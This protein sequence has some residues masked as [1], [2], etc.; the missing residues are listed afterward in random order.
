[1]KRRILILLAAAAALLCGCREEAGPRSVE[2]F[3]FGWRFKLG[4]S[5]DFDYT[6]FDKEGLRWASA[7]LDDS[8]WRSLHL[9][10]DW[11]V[12]GEF[13]ALN[14]STPSGGALPG[15]VGWYRKTFETPEGAGEGKCVS[16][17]FDG[18]FMNSTVYVNGRSL[19]TR[20]YGYSSFSYDITPLLNPEGDDNIIAVRCD[21]NDQ[22]NSRW[23]AGCGIYR[24]VRLVTTGRT[25]VAWSGTYVTVSAITEANA[26]ADVEV[27][28]DG[29][30]PDGTT[31]RNTVRG[32]N[33]NVVIQGDDIPASARVTDVLTIVKPRL[34]DIDDT[35]LYTLETTVLVDGEPVDVYETKFGIRTAEFDVNHGFFLNGRRVELQG[36][37]LH[38]DMGCLGTAVHYRALQR[39]LETLKGFG[40]N[41]IRTSH[42]PPAPELLQLCD[43][44]G[45]LVIDEAFDMWR[46]R[47]TQYDYA[48]FFDE[49]HE[50]DL[51]DF[52]RRDRNHPCIIMWSIGNEL[53]E[54]GDSSEDLLENL[55]PEQANV[56]LNFMESFNEYTEGD[57]NPNIVL[58][59]HM[60]ALVKSMDTT[61]PITAGCNQPFE[62]N[63]L[64]RSGAMEVFGINYHTANYDEVRQWC[65][66]RPIYGSETASSLNSRGVYPQPST[67]TL[68]VPKEWWM[69]Y[70]TP[71]H[72]CT[73][74]DAC[75][76]PWAEL[77]E[78]AW[79]RIRDREWMAGTFVWTGF[80]YLGE[81][82]PY[83]WPSRSSY[84][85]VCDLAG[86]PKDI[87]WMYKSEWTDETVIHLFPHWNWSPGD[88]IDVWVYY[89]NADEVELFLNGHS[90][91][92]D[93][94][95][96]EKLHAQWLGVPFE[97]GRLEAI[98]YLNGRVV[99][100]ESRQTT[101]EPVR[102]RLTADRQVID[103]DGYDLAY[104]TVEALD[105]SGREVPTAD[106]M[107][108][109]KVTGAGELVGVDN[110]N[111]ADT[112]S[113]KGDTK[114][115]FNGKALA[116][117][118]SFRGIPGS[119]RLTVETE[120]HGSAHVDI[121][122]K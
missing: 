100:R 41:A 16:V 112:M 26:V 10:H 9:P 7:D 114:A 119:A 116:V 23:Y 82:T 19:G 97:P 28:L 118:R 92:R 88:K 47:K 80:D 50:R 44:M 66:D 69:T 86:F 55:T 99:A 110:G 72:Q 57:D 70:D 105:A 76:A 25:H 71:D 24:N 39:E 35:Y 113:L 103:A 52:I 85:G 84:F 90:L 3:N 77:H 17:E 93:R 11:S 98:S 21:N 40:V 102:L 73:A 104:V 6:N 36:V 106:W 59:K 34:W 15:G 27:V 60:A 63:N 54:Q 96:G 37:C 48:R 117:V 75:R 109:F 53:P 115:L 5:P 31:V 43:E 56:L 33:G 94:K 45:F 108:K 2:D 12:E 42:N 20:P 79:V 29:P 62:W 107:L 81:P 30:I 83:S 68:I 111:S 18:V 89:N 61:R 122:I 101:S 38:H 49:W 64:Y 65:P 46:K 4:D 32:A 8:E 22:P 120:G 67:D 14:P 78:E 91:G 74:Y 51:T 121:K 87:Y 58:A 95:E 1:M 13:S